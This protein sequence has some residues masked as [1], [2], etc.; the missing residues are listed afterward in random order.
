MSIEVKSHIEKEEWLVSSHSD[1]KLKTQASRD[2]KLKRQSLVQVAAC[3]SNQKDLEG[4]VFS[5]LPLPI[6]TGLPVHVNGSFM[7]NSSR[8]D[9]FTSEDDNWNTLLRDLGMRVAYKELLKA[10]IDEPNSYRFWPIASKTHSKFWADGLKA[11]CKVEN[12]CSL[13]SSTSPWKSR[14]FSH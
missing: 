7:L 2:K 8:T 11:V 4:K 13:F 12:F 5:F 10:L 9:I 1:P 3:L 6:T 14:L